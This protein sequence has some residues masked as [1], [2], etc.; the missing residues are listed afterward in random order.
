MR[1]RIPPYHD[2]DS[3]LLTRNGED[4]IVFR[5]DVIVLVPASD[6][7]RDRRVSEYVKALVM[8]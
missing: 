7:I 4:R 3:G 1:D 8:V 2:I 6:D 5:D